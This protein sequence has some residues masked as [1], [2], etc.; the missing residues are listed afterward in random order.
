MLDNIWKKYETV[1]CDVT[2]CLHGFFL[3]DIEILKTE[4]LL[5]EYYRLKN[6]YSILSK[7]DRIYLLTLTGE[8]KRRNIK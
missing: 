6:N 2:L 5:K 7:C 4:K 1:H 3:K 8:L